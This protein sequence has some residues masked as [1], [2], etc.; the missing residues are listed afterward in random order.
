MNKCKLVS[1]NTRNNHLH[2]I[3]PRY[4]C[5]NKG[6]PL[7]Y[8]LYHEKYY[9]KDHLW[10][11]LTLMTLC[12]DPPCVQQLQLWKLNFYPFYSFEP[13][14]A[15]QNRTT[16]RKSFTSTVHPN[17]YDNISLK[18]QD[19][20]NFWTSEHPLAQPVSYCKNFIPCV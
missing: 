1:D 11:K 13:K 15:P 10:D 17:T 9:Q 20:V 4:Y 5:A 12:L 16:N 18:R 3:P 8:N 19:T 14:I 6:A 7:Y 2:N